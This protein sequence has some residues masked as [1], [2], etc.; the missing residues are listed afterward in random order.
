MALAS[1]AQILILAMLCVASCCR[2]GLASAFV[3]GAYYRLGD[4]DPG[5]VIDGTGNNP[6][7]DSFGGKLNLDRFGMPRYSADVPARGPFGNTFSMA[8]ANDGLGGPAV[9][10]V[11]GREPSIPM[12]EQ[13]YALEAWVKAAPSIGDSIHESLVAY[14]G[15]PASSGFGLF[16]NGDNYVARVGTFE[17]VLGPAT[18][19]E[20]HHLAYVQSL[21]TVGY[22]YDGKLVSETASDPIPMAATGGFWLG[23][24][25]NVDVGAGSFLFN[26]W[27][28][29]VRYQSFNPLAAGAFN[30]TAFLITPVPEPG[31]VVLATTACMSIGVVLLLRGRRRLA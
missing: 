8:F 17:R 20:W 12:V 21:G 31:T 9:P 6:T 4:D 24:M 14:N 15:D 1:T 27:I 3:Q 11:Y 10:G 26:G 5:A 25:G 7:Q 16:L 2:D 19:G 23:G 30:P 29:E 13:G 18:V 28:D 22:Y